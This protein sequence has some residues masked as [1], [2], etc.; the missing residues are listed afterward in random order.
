MPTLIAILLSMQPLYA[1]VFARDLDGFEAA[2]GVLVTQ[3]FEGIAAGT[4]ITNMS[5]GGI[6]FGNGDGDSLIVVIAEETYSSGAGGP[7]HLL[8]ATTPIN[9]LSPGGVELTY[10]G[11][12]QNDD[13][14]LTFSPPVEAFGLDFLWQSADYNPGTSIVVYDE[15][16][17]PI[18]NGV[19]EITDLGGAG[20]PGGTDFWGIVS[21]S[22]PIAS[23]HI[24][25]QDEG[26]G[27]P[28]SN[29]GFDT[30]RVS[31]PTGVHEQLER[32]TWSVTKA[33]FR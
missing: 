8:I 31:A 1:Q 15:E 3:D 13:L 4:D 9:V 28:D 17:L 30:I 6:H 18:F 14:L 23:V 20:A 7:E 19:P 12:L 27:N 26:A 29:I 21:S 10:E 16:G 33:L 25:E 22:Q 5:I 2:A 32:I 11:E 24:D